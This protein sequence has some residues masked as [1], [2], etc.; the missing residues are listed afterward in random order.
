MPT[1]VTA[2]IF[3][4]CQGS[5]ARRERNAQHA[6]HEDW[7]CFPYVWEVLVISRGKNASFFNRWKIIS[8][9]V[10]SY[11][12]TEEVWACCYFCRM[13]DLTEHFI[14]KQKSILKHQKLLR[15]DVTLRAENLGEKNF[16]SFFLKMPI[17]RFSPYWS[18]VISEK[19]LFTPSFNFFLDFNSPWYDLLVSHSHK[20]SKNAKTMCGSSITALVKSRKKLSRGF[21][22]L[23]QCAQYLSYH[24]L[25]AYR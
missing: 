3:C 23:F 18:A 4:A 10:V 21:Q 2:H 7:V 19:C 11:L 13:I 22:R 24:W 8:I 17:Q 1:I 5:R 14:V 16:L 9:Y 15:Q 6:G 20:C 25:R 12:K